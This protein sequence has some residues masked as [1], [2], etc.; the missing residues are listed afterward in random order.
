[1]SFTASWLFKNSKE[2]PEFIEMGKTLLSRMEASLV[3]TNGHSA[4]PAPAVSEQSTFQHMMP[5][6]TSRYCAA[7]TH[8]HVATGDIQPKRR[9][10]SGFYAT[11]Y[12]QS[13]PGLF[14]TMFQLVNERKPKTKREDWY[15]QHLYT[16]C[17]ILEA[18]PILPEL[19]SGKK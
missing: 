18:M 15:S 3:H 9:A 12:M 5:G 10:L 16:V 2:N 13:E 1:M 19:K 7:L 4:A 8:L 6:H 11:T 14:R 17:H